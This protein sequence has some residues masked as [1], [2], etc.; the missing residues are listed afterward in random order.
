M[1]KNVQDYQIEAARTINS[2]LRS[3]PR[4]LLLNACL[5]LAGESGEFIEIVKKWAHQGHRLDID[6]AKDE[7][8]DVCWYIAEACTALDISMFDVMSSN[9]DK[10]RIRYPEKF[11]PDASIQRVDYKI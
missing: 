9:I 4:E 2:E 1:T 8:G 7:L 6:K 3:D 10:L 5:G 11:T